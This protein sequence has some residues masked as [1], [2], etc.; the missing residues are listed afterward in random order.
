MHGQIFYS[1]IVGLIF[2]T[3]LIISL[4]IL[5]KRSKLNT[6]FYKKKLPAIFFGMPK[7]IKNIISTK[8]NNKMTKK[9]YRNINSV[10][11]KISKT[12][13]DKHQNSKKV[14][15]KFVFSNFQSAKLSDISGNSK[16]LKR[17]AKNSSLYQN[18]FNT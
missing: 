9:S 14:E 7:S 12:T 5:I 17:V 2:L 10:N 16:Y 8:N 15:N 1:A 13:K 18:L 3:L 6:I 11:L 4:L